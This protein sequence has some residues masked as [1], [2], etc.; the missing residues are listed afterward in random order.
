MLSASEVTEGTP[1]GLYAC[2]DSSS[3][4]EVFGKIS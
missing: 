2:M 3:I 4:Y 1:T